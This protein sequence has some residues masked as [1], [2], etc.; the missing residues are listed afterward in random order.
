MSAVLAAW[1]RENVGFLA[2]CG[3]NRL[4]PSSLKV[5]RRWSEG[6]LDID[7]QDWARAE[8][9]A[10]K[11]TIEPHLQAIARTACNADDVDPAPAGRW[12]GPS[13]MACEVVP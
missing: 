6:V 7:Q 9:L 11:L 3:Y 12:V 1:C 5:Q 8:A 13:G 10:L 4:D 2:W